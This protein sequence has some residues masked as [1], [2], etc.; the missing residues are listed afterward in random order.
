ME[1]E[2]NVPEFANKIEIINYLLEKTLKNQTI[3][4]KDYK[5]FIKKIDGNLYHFFI[6]SEKNEII[7]KILQILETISIFFVLE[8]QRFYTLKLNLKTFFA[9][10]LRNTYNID[11]LDVYFKKGAKQKLIDL[12]EIRIINKFKIKK[13][14]NFN[15]IDANLLLKIASFLDLKSL[16]GLIRVSQEI[17]KRFFE[18]NEFWYSLYQSKFKK[19]GFKLN[20]LNWKLAYINEMKKTIKK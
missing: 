14:W 6:K 2:K 17:N 20:L 4:D 18:N 11:K 12:F 3:F 19:T 5:V 7:I 9:P 10:Q 1:I 8:P 13:T 15:E 16:W